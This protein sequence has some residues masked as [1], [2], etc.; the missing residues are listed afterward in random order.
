MND[1]MKAHKLLELRVPTTYQA[2][3]QSYIDLLKIWHPDKHPLNSN[4]WLKA[5]DKCKE[6]N[7]AWTVVE[8]Y[9]KNNEISINQGSENYR[10][11]INRDDTTPWERAEFKRAEEAL[12][13][14]RFKQEARREMRK[15]KRRQQQE[16]KKQ[17]EHDRNLQEIKKLRKQLI[18]N[19]VFIFSIFLMTAL[20]IRQLLHYKATLVVYFGL[21]SYLFSFL[22]LG[23]LSWI[24]YVKK[25]DH[26]VLTKHLKDRTSAQEAKR[27]QAEY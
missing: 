25:S 17:Q 26:K 1:V 23:I 10:E 14:E 5:N 24:F 3:R 15:A 8:D 20:V 9:L 19:K 4:L 21:F 22:L 6:I 7:A 18:L 2:A 12:K 13:Q 11:D 27:G 16:E